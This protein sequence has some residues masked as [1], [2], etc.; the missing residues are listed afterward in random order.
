[1]IDKYGIIDDVK[2]ILISVAPNLMTIDSNKVFTNYPT[3]SEPEENFIQI[4]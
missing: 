4:N 2:G 3:E 1:M